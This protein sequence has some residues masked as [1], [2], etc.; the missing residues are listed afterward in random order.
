VKRTAIALAAVAA[1]LLHAGGAAAATS[2]PSD[3]FFVNHEQWGLTGAPASINAPAA[4]CASTGAG[5]TIADV[6]SGANMD[7]FDLQGKLI[8]GVSFLNGNGSPSSAPGDPAGVMDDNG[9]GTETAGVMGAAT[10]NAHGIAGVAPDAK[11]LVVRVLKNDPNTGGASGYDADVSAGIRYAAD[12]AGVKVINLS[13]GPEVPLVLQAAGGSDIPNAIQYAYSKGVAVAVAAG[14][15]SSPVG[16]EYKVGSSAIVVGAVGPAGEVAYYSNSSRLG[17]SASAVH[18]YA[19]GGDDLNTSQP[20][21]PDGV[22]PFIV[23]TYLTIQGK[24]DSYSLTN[25]GTSFAAPHV[26]GVLALLM[27]KGMSNQQAMQQV[28][29]TAARRNGGG[30]SGMVPEL[31]AAAALGVPMTQKCGGAS[32]VP[33][34]PPGG[35]AGGTKGTSPAPAPHTPTP[36]PAANGGPATS[37]P[38][39]QATTP[40]PSAAPPT[41][42]PQSTE[43]GTVPPAA[44]IARNGSSGGG[45]SPSPLLLGV[46]AAV[47]V[48]GAPTAT[49]ALRRMRAS[50]PR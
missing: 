10:D 33:P 11:V 44:A 25:E 1:A 12:Y 21:G 31:D 35:S 8:A 40:T 5:V 4:W 15:N 49:W 6:D 30:T 24:T 26:A 42:G 39:A 28:I 16:N 27:A 37:A 43:P 45:G 2:G 20:N 22:G 29:N 38:V 36:H 19:P 14:N 13:I 32:T 7:N 46:L 34:V 18:V 50:R 17:S 48:V 3:Y 23:S 9:H 41:P 47:V